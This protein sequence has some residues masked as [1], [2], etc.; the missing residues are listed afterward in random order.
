MEQQFDVMLD[1]D[2][3]DHEIEPRVFEQLTNQGCPPEHAA[4]M[5]EAMRRRVT[6]H[7]T[8][9]AVRL[10]AEARRHAADAPAHLLALI[11][12]QR[13]LIWILTALAAGATATALL[14]MWVWWTW[15]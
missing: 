2:V 10:A 1:G 14:W 11:A 4:H 15:R 12:L 8:Q 9:E 3:P 6:D 7:R 13:R 5:A